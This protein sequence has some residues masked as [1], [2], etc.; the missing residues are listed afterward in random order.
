MACNCLPY[1]ITRKDV[2]YLCMPG[3]HEAKMCLTRGYDG[4]TTAGAQNLAESSLYRQYVYIHKIL[5]MRERTLH[6]RVIF[7]IV[8][9]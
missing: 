4:V 7:M 3:S 9:I 2:N 8:C 6:V 5:F 1:K